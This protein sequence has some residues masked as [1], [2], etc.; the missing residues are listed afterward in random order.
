[1][2]LTKIMTG[3]LHESTY[4]KESYVITR[5]RKLNKYIWKYPTRNVE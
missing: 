2:G 3:M 5:V 4:W 1:M